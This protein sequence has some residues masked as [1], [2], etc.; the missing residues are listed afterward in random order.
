MKKGHRAGG[1]LTSSHTT[2]TDL[3]G[4]VVDFLETV[5]TVQKVSLGRL[6]TRSGKSSGVRRVKI[7]DDTGC[8]LLELT[9]NRSVQTIRFF[10]CS[11]HQAKLALARFV[12]DNGM[13]LRFGCRV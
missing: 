8:I 13:E 11:P 10:T 4:T 3:G 6:R 5:H 7:S 9:Q 12:R 2:V 1:K